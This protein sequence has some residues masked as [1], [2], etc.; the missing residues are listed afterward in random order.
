MG[1]KLIKIFIIE[2]ILIVLVFSFFYKKNS[3]T[4]NISFKG[5]YE[6]FT[7]STF[8]N[9]IMNTLNMDKNL[10]DELRETLKDGNEFVVV[11]DKA[12]FKS[13]EEIFDT[14]NDIVN[15]D[16]EIMYY[17]S[18]EYINGRLKINYSRP[19]EILKDNQLKLQEKRDKIVDDIIHNSMSDYEKIK[20]IHDYIVNNSHYDERLFTDGEVPPESY[21]AYGNLV[22]G[23]GVCEGYAKSMKYLL[24]KVGIES[25]VIV[26]TSKNQNHAWNLVKIDNEYYHIDATWDDPV[27]DNGENII[28]YNYF[29]LTDEEIS[30]THSWNREDYPKA[31]GSLYNYFKYNNLL[32]NTKKELTEKLKNKLMDRKAEILFKYDNY[33]EDKISI[34][35]IIEDIAYNNY[36]LI[37]LKSY[38]YSIDENHGIFKINF[39]YH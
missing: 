33:K 39:Y 32:I 31:T 27:S 4:S 22:L 3:N 12:L 21:T 11:R 35:N 36:K 30:R 16:A 10:E 34:N 13:P 38:S 20:A 8:G 6:N 23:I 2:L 18:V 19:K 14:L 28:Q 17:S 7:S 9:K 15:S 25:I 26:G 37:K 5:I 29:N 1:K 24:D